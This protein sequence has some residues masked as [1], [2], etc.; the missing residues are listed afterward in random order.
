M[1]IFFCDECGARVTDLDLRAGKGMRQRNDQICSQC[2]GSGL[3]AAWLTRSGAAVPAQANGSAGPAAV[4][5]AA[6]D[7]ISLGRDRALTQREDPSA[8]EVVEPAALALPTQAKEGQETAEMPSLRP[9]PS[10]PPPSAHESSPFGDGFA[11][12]AGAMGALAGPLPSR[13]D[14]QRP[15]TGVDDLAEGGEQD[16]LDQAPPTAG[17]DVS[18]EGI[19]AAKAETAALPAKSEPKKGTSSRQLAQKKNGST[20]R[21]TVSGTSS[22]RSAASPVASKKILVL[23]LVS[24]AVIA[25]IFFGVVLPGVNAGP[26]G[27][28]KEDRQDLLVNFAVF[29]KEADT[30][31]KDAMNKSRDLPSQRK[32]MAAIRT[33]QKEYDLFEKAATKFG[34]REDGFEQ[35]LSNMHYQ[36]ILGRLSTINNNITIIEQQNRQP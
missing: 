7:P 11:E 26:R 22:R 1:D 6:S 5:V 3:A 33:M 14:G 31:T 18:P 17:I 30:L 15:D 8:D 32:A 36:D 4:A 29:V 20:T 21:R 23:S 24:C 27:P 28:Q 10:L 2:V 35:Q 12:A 13:Q 19:R 34:W 16:D 9:S 25:G